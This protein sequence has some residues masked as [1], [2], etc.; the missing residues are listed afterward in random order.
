MGTTAMVQ[1]AQQLHWSTVLGSTLFSSTSETRTSKPRTPKKRALP[2][3]RPTQMLVKFSALN[4]TNCM[5]T[6]TQPTF[7]SP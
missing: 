3:N 5:A 7:N 6:S 1:R 4:K 2:P